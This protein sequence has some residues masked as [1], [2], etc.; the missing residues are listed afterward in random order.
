MNIIESIKYTLFNKYWWRRHLYNVK[1]LFSPQNKWARK[2][3]P[4]QFTDVDCIFE[5]TLFNGLIFF[6]EED[7]GEETLR[8]QFEAERDDFCDA[9][10][11]NERIAVCK[12]VYV[13]MNNAYAW[14]KIR[15]REY[16]KLGVDWEKEEELVET[17]TLHLTNIIKYR[18]YLW[19]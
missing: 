3:I 4:R 11:W 14:A 12:E 8:Y 6:W 10:K 7:H 17:D 1:C 2:G 13:A 15:E 16:D 9:D 5:N 19:T 18:K